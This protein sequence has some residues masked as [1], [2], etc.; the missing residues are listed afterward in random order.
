M[1]CRDYADGGVVMTAAELRAELLWN[2]E[3]ARRWAARVAGLSKYKRARAIHTIARVE[4]VNTPRV[5]AWV[6]WAEQEGK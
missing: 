5:W 6:R 3:R 1:A 2:E 4:N